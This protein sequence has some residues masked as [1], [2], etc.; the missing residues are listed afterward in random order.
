MKQTL[1]DKE[2]ERLSYGYRKRAL[3][4]ALKAGGGHLAPAFSAQDIVTLLYKDFL[5]VDPKNPQWPDRDRFIL[6]KGHACLALYPVLADLGF[7]PKEAL[8][9]FTQPGALLGGHSDRTVPGVEVNTGS[10]GHGLPLAVGMA[11]AR[12]IDKKAFRVVTVLS[13]GECQE[14]STWEAAQFAGHHKLE[15]MLAIVDYNK[16]QSLGRVADILSLEPFADRWKSFGWSVQEADGHD[17]SSLRNALKK[18]PFEKSRPSVIIA[19]TVKGKGVSFMENK[20]IWHYRNPNKEEL[21][22]AMAELAA[23]CGG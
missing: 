11:F 12:N 19:H 14:G 21:P 13:D 15:H 4:M 22:I 2:L 1:S 16:F 10:L 3:E 6:S 7:F 9:S 8:D 20:P 18:F 23:K 5:N 17:F